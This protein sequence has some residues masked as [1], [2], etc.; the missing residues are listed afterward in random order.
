M[1]VLT[2]SIQTVY[3]LNSITKYNDDD[4]LLMLTIMIYC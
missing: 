3:L 2:Y 1:Y 4:R